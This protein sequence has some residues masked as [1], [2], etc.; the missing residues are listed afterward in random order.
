MK[1]EPNPSR[2]NWAVRILLTLM[3]AMGMSAA[4]SGSASAQISAPVPDGCNDVADHVPLMDGA[5]VCTIGVP[6]GNGGSGIG[7]GPGKALGKAV[8]DIVEKVVII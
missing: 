2:K 4:L 6:P 5:D 7:S 3:V 1:A 8:G